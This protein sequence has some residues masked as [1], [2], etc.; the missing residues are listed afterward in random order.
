[1]F[2]KFSGVLRNGRVCFCFLALRCLSRDL[3]PRSVVF[4]H[5]EARCLG[6]LG[7]DGAGSVFSEAESSRAR[8]MIAVPAVMTDE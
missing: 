1:M 4:Q 8:L 3:L 6:F 2:L 5:P 7:S